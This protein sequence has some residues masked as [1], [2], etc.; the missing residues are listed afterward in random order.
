MN[1]FERMEHEIDFQK[2]YEKLESIVCNEDFSGNDDT[3]NDWISDNFRSWKDHGN[4]SSFDELRE[5]EGFPIQYDYSDRPL[6][7]NNKLITM[8]DFFAYVE[9][10]INIS[11]SLLSHRDKPQRNLSQKLR[12]F[13]DIAKVDIDKV[14]Y[15]LKEVF[16]KWYVLQKNA[17]A[18]VVVEHIK[19]SAADAV[20]EYN[21]YVLKGDLSRKKELLKIIADDLE[22]QKKVLEDLK[23]GEAHQFFDLVNNCNIRHNNFDPC[24]GKKYHEKLSRSADDL[25]EKIY[26]LIYE[27]GLI[28]YL[29][30]DRNKRDEKVTAIRMLY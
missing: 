18:S 14:G 22:P 16:G 23:C 15:E 8:D 11:F 19:P 27:L 29:A 5:Q 3:I 20:M 10:I 2:E 28:S 9:M 4:F 6:A 24:G 12:E 25:I 13:T 7:V 1:F 17:A 26:D 21:H 30:L